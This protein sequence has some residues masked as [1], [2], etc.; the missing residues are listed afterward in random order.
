[1]LISNINPS[2]APLLT[3]L[4]IQ[5]PLLLA[6]MAGSVSTPALAA[7]VSNH[8]GLGSLGGG[9]LSP[10]QLEAQ[11]Q[12][13]Q[14]LTSKPINV[15]LFIPSNPT[16]DAD[17]IARMQEK[18]NGFR[19]KLGIPEQTSFVL[20]P[21][22]FKEQLEIVITYRI[23]IFSFTFGVLEPQYRRALK[24]NNTIIMGT[25]TN[26]LEAK[27]LEKAGCDVIVAQGR[28]AGGHRGTFIGEAAA[29]LQGVKA[30]TAQLVKE[31]PLPIIAA[32]GIMDGRDLEEVLALGAAA[33]QLGSA[34]L[35]CPESGAAKSYKERVIKSSGADTVLTRAF[36]GRFAR[37]INNAFIEAFESELRIPDYPVQHYLTQDIRQAA[38]Q[39]GEADYLSLWAGQGIDALIDPDRSVQMIMEEIKSAF[40]IS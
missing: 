19:R 18:L 15:N 39:Q 1:M 13:T 12:E 9:Y 36:S 30:L 4:D 24:A 16:I 35:I 11:I 34:F 5:F 22:Q 29:S 28:E 31:I 8:G 21:N 33:A 26:L 6:P 2:I 7:S 14:K 17:C 3:L 27:A 23:P 25:A 32:G 40:K 38:A 37:G 10:E 20:P